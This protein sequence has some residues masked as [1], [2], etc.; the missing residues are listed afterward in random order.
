MV[1]LNNVNNNKNNKK[2]VNSSAEIISWKPFPKDRK[3]SELIK[4]SK[5]FIIELII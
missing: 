1:W 4:I 2:D 5:H 3:M